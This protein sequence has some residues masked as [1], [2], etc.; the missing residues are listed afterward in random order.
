MKKEYVCAIIEKIYWEKKGKRRM[1]WNK[2]TLKTT[3][4][5]TDLVGG[6][7]AEL[8]IEGIEIQD[9]IPISEEDRK[10]M[11]ID[12]LPELPLDEGI[13]YISFYM[14]ETED[15]T[16]KLNEIKAGLEE[17]AMFTDVGECSIE[18]DTTEDKDWINN[19]KKFFKAFTV[20]D[21]VIKPT[22]EEADKK[23]EGKLV[24]EIDPGTAFG[25][26]MH[27]TTQLCIRALRKYINEDT[28][29]LD[30]GCGSGILAIVALKL[31]AKAAVGVDID[32]N[33]ITATYENLAVNKIEENKC[34]AYA[35]NVLDDEEFG[36]KIGLEAYDVVVAN[37]LADVVIPL[38][39]IVPK[40]LK[41]GGVFITSGIIN[42]KE[43]DVVEKIKS[44]PE[45]EII[46]VTR[47]ND[48]SSVTARKI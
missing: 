12:F 8:G 19:W 46:E 9:N 42:T 28:N 30:L 5:A 36:T 21:I 7:L 44:N 14:E 15:E 34:S 43:K 47:Q 27:E 11:Y 24:I 25:T 41:K 32:D 38:T 39:D 37:I 3:T 10:K 22:W 48:W 35:G 16:K 6:M 23:D 13:A 31:G 20:D 45:F 2:F 18:R 29:I 1:K 4:A 40:H 33:A 17:L 26:G